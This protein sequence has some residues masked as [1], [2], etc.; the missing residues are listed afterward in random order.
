MRYGLILS[1]LS[2]FSACAGGSA[3]VGV[4][5]GRNGNDGQNG[6]N[7][8]TGPT[9]P[10]GLTGPTGAT[11]AAASSLSVSDL[12]VE[13][14]GITLHVVATL[15]GAAPTSAGLTVSVAGRVVSAPAVV[16]GSTVTVDVTLPVPCETVGRDADVGVAYGAA[17]TW[18]SLHLAGTG[19]HVG[20]RTDFYTSPDQD[21]GSPGLPLVI[22]GNTDYEGDEDWE[23]V[24]GVA[25]T[26][27]TLYVG[28]ATA[29]LGLVVRSIG[30][31]ILD[32]D[33]GLDEL[34]VPIANNS[35]LLGVTGGSG[36]ASDWTL[37]VE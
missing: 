30:G 37:V 33:D 4:D 17:W 35:V 26:T 36:P 7:G 31:T 20:E 23:T 28:S 11:G 18:T 2:S 5:D 19:V 1:V 25:S 10:T 9:G 22:C 27:A 8:P 34:S 16:S 14:D 24:A 13:Q 12:T 3:A 32:S 6:A 21:L 15:D 29:E